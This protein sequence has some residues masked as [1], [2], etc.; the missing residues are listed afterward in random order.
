MWRKLKG[1]FNKYIF[2]SRNFRLATLLS[3]GVLVAILLSFLTV[4]AILTL[5]PVILNFLTAHNAFPSIRWPSLVN[6]PLA[7]GV[8]FIVQVSASYL[9]APVIDR[10]LMDAVGRAHL[11]TP[12]HLSILYGIST[13]IIV[14]FGY[15]AKTEV[16]SNA[17]SEHSTIITL[18]ALGLSLIALYVTALTLRDFRHVINTF[19]YFAVR[20]SVMLEEIKS[21]RDASNFIRIMAYTPLPG[22]LGLSETPRSGGDIYS[23][24]FSLLCDPDVRVEVICLDES[25]LSEWMKSF[26]GK[27]LAFGELT[28]AQIKKANCDVTNFINILENPDSHYIGNPPRIEFARNHRPLRGTVEELPHF[29][30]Y[31]TRERAI[32]INPLF[33]PLPNLPAQQQPGDLRK[34]VVEF[35]GFETTDTHTIKNL[36]TTYSLVATQIM[37]K[38]SSPKRV[39]P[40]GGPPAPAVQTTG[41]TG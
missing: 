16:I 3:V 19:D 14:A 27:A 2:H 40:T 10:F 30:A 23:R 41:P 6:F 7:I 36:E 21:D 29:F 22:N 9:L 20:F 8:T 4:I 33:N 31:F 1:I 28:I 34:R 39:A 35:V 5:S 15:D 25:A 12:M 38:G 13:I 32:V 17:V 37:D 26:E 11:A 24:L 18:I